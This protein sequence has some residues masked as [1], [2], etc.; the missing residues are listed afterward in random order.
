M[1]FRKHCLRFLLLMW[2]W[3]GLLFTPFRKRRLQKNESVKS[4]SL[5]GSGTSAERIL[6]ELLLLS[7]EFSYEKCS[8]IF[9][10]NF[11]PL[12]CGSEKILLNSHQIPQ[13]LP[14]EKKHRR[15]SAGAQGELLMLSVTIVNRK[16]YANRKRPCPPEVPPPPSCKDNQKNTHTHTYTHT[17]TARARYLCTAGQHTHTHTHTHTHRVRRSESGEKF[18]RQI[19]KIWE[20]SGTMKNT[21][22]FSNPSLS[23]R[24]RSFFSGVPVAAQGLKGNGCPC[25]H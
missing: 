4:S 14:H 24:F 12:F 8:K 19:K 16:A 20:C 6:H 23:C 1:L 25:T 15:A 7:Y 2:S 3:K 22:T 11:E 10:E 13:K 17:H 21:Q 18:P 9:P 5:G